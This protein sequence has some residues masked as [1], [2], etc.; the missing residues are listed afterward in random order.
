MNNDINLD[1][2]ETEDID[3]TGCNP[4]I[5]AALKRGKNIKCIGT[6]YNNETPKEE[7]IVERY[8]VNHPYP[9]GVKTGYNLKHAEPIKTKKVLYVKSVECI[10]RS[11]SDNNYKFQGRGFSSPD[12]DACF[13]IE[14]FKYCGQE[15][16][17]VFGWRPEWL[18]EREE[19]E[20]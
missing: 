19:V 20:A 14:M 3:F 12:E 8:C 17:D 5:A 6:M 4:V 7:R 10:L 16:P 15:K 2:Y 18:E 11:L 1:D 9:Y 13:I